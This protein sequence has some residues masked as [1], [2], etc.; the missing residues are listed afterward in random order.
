MDFNARK[1]DGSVC[2]VAPLSQEG[3]T[4]RSKLREVGPRVVMR[5]FGMKLCG[6]VGRAFGRVY[7]MCSL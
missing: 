1:T 7:R 5:T 6:I 2:I 4:S 3:G